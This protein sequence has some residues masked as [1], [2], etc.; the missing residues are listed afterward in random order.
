MKPQTGRPMKAVRAAAP[1][2]AEDADL[3]DPGA[4]AEVKAQQVEEGT[5]KYGAEPAKPFTSED[6][7]PE[8]GQEDTWIEIELLDEWGEPRGGERYEVT[9]P[10]GRVAE[11]T[12]DMDG[13]ARVTGVE[14]GQCEVAFPDMDQESWQYTGSSQEGE[15]GGAG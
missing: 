4:M 12:L 1:K 7:P 10:D 14:P 13:R 15:D 9:V 5:G 8:E 2:Q 6:E 3:S 11:G